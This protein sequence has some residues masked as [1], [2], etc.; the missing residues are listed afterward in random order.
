LKTILATQHNFRDLGGIPAADG[1]K[2]KPGVLFRSG[3]LYSLSGDDIR[4]LEKMKLAMIIDLRAGRE[5]D[6]RPDKTIATVKEIVHIDIHDAARDKAEKFLE[7]NDAKGLES[8][9]IGDYV[10]MV[11][12]H[13]AD[14]RQ[15]LDLV[16]TTG[17]LPLV[18]HCAAGKDRTGMATV[19][20]L[21]ALG[22]DIRDIWVDY[23]ATNE[24]T[25]HA[26]DK[27]INKVT[28]S[29]MNGGILR[30]LLEVREEYLR[31]ALT[32]IDRKYGG[33]ECYV[34]N[35]LK[36]DSAKLKEK[37]LTIL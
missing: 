4:K 16:A 13:Q 10:Q 30:P 14:F 6:L 28:A 25:A 31:A 33:L 32:E 29:G 12:L 35:I 27:I 2:I 19:F 23:M 21:A 18:Y 7:D 8:V 1:M 5:I 22:V 37:Y 26:A 34:E 36:A 11:D 15:F 9:L 17:N 20:L 24:F 3:D